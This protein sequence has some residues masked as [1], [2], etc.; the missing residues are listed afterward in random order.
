MKQWKY[1][2]FLLNDVPVR[3]E[4][5]VLI[6]YRLDDSKDRVP[7]PELPAV[8]CLV[9]RPGEPPLDITRLRLDR[10]IMDGRQIRYVET[11][12]PQMARIAHIQSDVVLNAVI[13]K[14]G[15]IA[16]LRTVSGHPILIQA[17]LDAVRQWTYQPF[18][19]HGEPIE[20]ES[21]VHVLF[22]L[23]VQEKKQ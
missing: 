13:D 5:T 9:R 12:Y 1:R 22:K 18:L 15:R 8:S 19:L 21:T 17:A 11:K 23:P 7:D 4:T 6:A 2:P 14:Q 16:R 10:E 20:V 3:V